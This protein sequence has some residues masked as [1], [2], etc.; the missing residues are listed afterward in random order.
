[1]ETKTKQFQHTK[2]WTPVWRVD[3]DYSGLQI[4]QAR[5]YKSEVHIWAII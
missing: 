1:M 3:L 5:G 4:V 2:I